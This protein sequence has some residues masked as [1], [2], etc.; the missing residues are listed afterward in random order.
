VVAT[1]PVPAR[2]ATPA[3]GTICGLVLDQNGAPLAETKLWLVRPWSSADHAVR[4]LDHYDRREQAG[5]TDANGRFCFEQV[6]LGVWLVGIAPA[7]EDSAPE[8]ITTSAVATTVDVT[9][10][11][12]T[13]TTELV[14]GRSLYLRGFVYQ[15]DGRPAARTMVTA[16]EDGIKGR[17]YAYTKKDGSFAIGPVGPRP[18]NL[19]VGSA[20]DATGGLAADYGPF[21]PGDELVHIYP[22]AG[23][24]IA[25]TI[26]DRDTGAGRSA[27]IYVLP[28]DAKRPVPIRQETD[29][30]GTFRLTQLDRERYYIVA[31]SEES[32]AVSEVI[33]LTDGRAQH[34]IEVA[35]ER[36]GF[37]R[38]SGRADN[39][40]TRVHYLV[41]GRALAS[42]TRLS[43]LP[44]RQLTPTGTVL[45][46]VR[47][48]NGD[49]MQE[50]LIEVQAGETTRVDFGRVQ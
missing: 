33:D 31:T 44:D 37:V 25:G 43:P 7:A 4:R 15:L 2:A 3:F 46:Q 41:D 13:V 29:A 34:G 47:A 17:L 35:L 16:T 38:V 6:G 5:E 10:A 14:V 26:V 30:D 11:G 21:Q 40:R 32:I 28:V 20:R 48:E 22:G 9:A 42:Q 36:G 27:Q 1:T 8:E 18:V 23:T 24:A 39:D 49:V 19:R 12:E 50:R 45:V